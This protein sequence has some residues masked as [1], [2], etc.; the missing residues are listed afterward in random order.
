MN[1]MGPD[2]R[3]DDAVQKMKQAKRDE[4]MDDGFKLSHELYRPFVPNGVDK[5]RLVPG[6]EAERLQTMATMASIAL[7][8]QEGRA[9]RWFQTH[10]WTQIYL[11]D[12]DGNRTSD[13]R[14]IKKD[15]AVYVREDKDGNLFYWVDRH[16]LA[17]HPPAYLKSDFSG[18]QFYIYST[19]SIMTSTKTEQLIETTYETPE[20][21]EMPLQLP[22]QRTNGQAGKEVEPI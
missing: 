8:Y 14:Y 21:S 12:A 5:V 17:L 9:R 2:Y 13:P 16:G 20:R 1:R 6:D 10:G 18:I 15:K 19:L 4:L 11:T 7:T 3:S 22:P